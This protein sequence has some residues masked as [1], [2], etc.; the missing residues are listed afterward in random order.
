M[1]DRSKAWKLFL[2]L[3]RMLLHRPEGVLLVPKD[4]FDDR[5]KRFNGGKW[6][7]LLDECTLIATRPMRT[8][9][10]M[11]RRAARA[12]ALV[13][14]GELSSARQ[15]LEAAELAPGNTFTL[16]YLQNTERRPDKLCSLMPASIL[17]FSPSSA[18]DLDK[19]RFIKNLRGSRKGASGGLTGMIA[20]LLKVCLNS[21]SST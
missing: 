11:E 20:E 1:E 21:D 4:K 6:L 19:Q 3:P 16:E 13:V 12:E 9:N 18:L 15:A 17:D 8:E 7:E 2:L 5:F 10:D 14:L